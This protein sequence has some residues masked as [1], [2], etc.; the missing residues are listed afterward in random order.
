MVQGFE[1]GEKLLFAYGNLNEHVRAVTPSMYGISVLVVIG[2]SFEIVMLVKHARK[3][4]S[5]SIAMSV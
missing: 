4:S 3:H 1:E 2:S 5:A